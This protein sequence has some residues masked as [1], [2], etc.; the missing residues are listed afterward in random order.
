MIDLTALRQQ[1][2]D[3]LG[4]GIGVGVADTRASAGGLLPQETAATTRMVEKRLREF[5]AGRRAARQ[6]MAA[7]N[8]APAPIPMGPD[9][10]PVW[11]QGLVGSIT[12]CDGAALAVVAQTSQ[13]R[14][15][16]IDIEDTSPLDQDLWDTVL[17]DAE[18][19]QRPNGDTAKQIFCA[20]E[21]VYKAQYPVTHERIA[22]EDLDVTLAKNG[23]RVHCR[24][25]HVHALIQ[26]GY[27]AA[28]TIQEKLYVSLFY[29]ALGA[30]PDAS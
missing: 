28:L 14:T 24:R 30:E 22:F 10:A 18:R 17:T 8:L 27:G 3:H 19:A 20:K 25:P 6:A 16:G 4:P 12:H 13:Y 26:A 15:L 7:L 23:M 29:Q 11:P 9:R 2:A 1:V 21:A 5:C